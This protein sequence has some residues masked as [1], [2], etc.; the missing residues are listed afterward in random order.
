M[1]GLFRGRGR[2]TRAQF[3]TLRFASPGPWIDLAHDVQPFFRLSERREVTHMEAEALT[4]LFEAAAHE[5]SEPLQ[6]GQISLC[7]RHRCR[8]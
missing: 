1:L 5:E 3:L 4:T 7:E 6:L 2:S 8:R